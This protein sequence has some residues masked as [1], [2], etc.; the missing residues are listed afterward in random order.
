MALVVG[1]VAAIVLLVYGLRRLR[2]RDRGSDRGLHAFLRH[3]E[4]SDVPPELSA[5]LHRALS[6]WLADG[7]GTVRANDP[8]DGRLGIGEDELDATLA[9]LLAEVR[10]T[11]A[12]PRPE[13]RTVDDLVRY[14]ATCPERSS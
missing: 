13:L 10:R 4:G 9:L 8:L 6:R 7:G 3:F 5:A 14:V 11:K 2:H 1:L 12:S